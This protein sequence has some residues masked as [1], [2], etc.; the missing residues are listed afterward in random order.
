[1]FITHWKEILGGAL[2]YTVVLA[3]AFWDQHRH[4]VLNLAWAGWIAV[5]VFSLPIVW[6]LPEDENAWRLALSFVG[7]C[8]FA[9]VGLTAYY[10]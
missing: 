9:L 5:P 1:M 6:W 4:P 2:F 3:P 10:A 8:W 7:L